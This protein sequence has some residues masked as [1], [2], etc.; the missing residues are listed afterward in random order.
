M[1][2]MPAIGANEQRVVCAPDQSA[3]LAPTDAALPNA[4]FGGWHFA[5]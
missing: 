4:S 5:S 2:R 3:P 1:G